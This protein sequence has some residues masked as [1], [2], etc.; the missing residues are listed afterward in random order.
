MSQRC[1]GAGS[2]VHTAAQ[3]P[4][5]QSVQCPSILSRYSYIASE[6]QRAVECCSYSRG[7][8]HA[9]S[10]T[11]FVPCE[12]SASK[13]PTLDVLLPALRGR[14]VA[15]VGDST[16]HQLWTGLVA[17]LFASGR[18]L[19][20]RQRVLEFDIRPQNLN[21]DD[22][23]TVSHTKTPRIGGC[24]NSF[25]FH[26]RATPSCNLT[27]HIG[28][29]ADERDWPLR[30]Q[31]HS[32]PDLELWLPGE[33]VRFLFFRV[34]ANR[35]KTVKPMWRRTH[36]HCQDEW[37][38]FGG[39]IDAAIEAA[40]AV[41][42][43]IGVWYAQAQEAVY[44]ADLRHL[45]TRLGTLATR[46]K[47]GLV[48]ESIVQHFPT[49]SGSGVFEEYNEGG[50]GRAGRRVGGGCR[51]ECAALGATYASRLDWRNAALRDLV[52]QSGFPAAQVVPVAAL[53]RP[54][55][56]LHK[57]TKWACKL[58]CTHYCY[59]PQVWAAMLDG[60]YRRLLNWASEPG[61]SARRHAAAAHGGGGLSGRRHVRPR[62]TKGRG[63]APYAEGGAHVEGRQ[64]ASRKPACEAATTPTPRTVGCS[65]KREK[66]AAWTAFQRALAAEAAAFS[67]RPAAASASTV[68]S[69][70]TTTTTRRLWLVG[71]SITEAWRGTAYGEPVARTVGIPAVLERTLAAH[72]P[73]PL[74]SAISADETQHVLWRLR[75]GHELSGALTSERALTVIVLIGTN[76]L[77]NAHQ[78]ADDTAAGILA[79]CRELLS[80]APH[81]RL[82]LNALLPRGASSEH[83]SRRRR[84][85][86]SLMPAV[87]RTNSLV[88]ASLP[89]LHTAFPGRV[90]M[91]DC[92]PPFVN[93]PEDVA[94]GQS[95]VI[96]VLMP[97]GVHPSPQGH[98]VWAQCLLQALR[99]WP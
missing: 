69:K 50:G 51:G 70:T 54:A 73:A 74:I 88:N 14:T 96:A 87:A 76:N 38:N 78:S 20:V 25:R 85:T 40:D 39:R 62:R 67:A 99:D 57:A 37:H 26:A 1:L 95:D 60:V 31:C 63:D 56:L 65:I 24:E 11:Q 59:H 72:Y 45:V 93:R 75:E 61:R 80:S 2:W 22:V 49:D 29:G 97:D 92:G 98:E 89:Q 21:R 41:V 19:D 90:R 58:D 16:M 71:D 44:R 47:L 17:E 8:R 35:S 55:P 36:G 27:G 3:P 43:N 23:C 53:L 32:L 10:T 18:P 94:N 12:G 7:G 5:P 79:V 4:L 48:R 15:L 46:G 6:Q 42:A 91:V 77:G 83:P 52:A 68:A 84:A 86:A 81:A 30:A 33:E 28:G 82:L 66:M 34:D 64:L 9:T 13:A